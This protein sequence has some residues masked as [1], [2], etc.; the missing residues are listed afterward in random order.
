MFPLSCRRYVICCG[1]FLAVSIPTYCIPFGLSGVVHLIHN[2]WDRHQIIASLRCGETTSAS[3]RT[4]YSI[5][6]NGQ[7][8]V[9]PVTS[10][11]FPGV[12]KLQR[13]E[14]PELVSCD[15]PAPTFTHFWPTTTGSTRSSLPYNLYLISS[16]SLSCHRYIYV[17]VYVLCLSRAVQPIHEN[18]DTQLG[19]ELDEIGDPPRVWLTSLDQPGCAFTR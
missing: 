12:P 16:F 17:F 15:W 11:S 5:M 19:D 1:L 13:P 14:R 3:P 10:R 4:Y 2:S 8:R 9:L 18:W 7:K 6:G